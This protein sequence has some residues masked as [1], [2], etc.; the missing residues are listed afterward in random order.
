MLDGAF[1]QLDDAITALAAVDV[2][3]LTPGELDA[4]VT[5]WMQARHRLAGA[6]ESVLARWDSIGVW[7]SDGSRSAAGRFSRD[8]ATSMTTA[9]IEL[10]RARTL[11]AMPAAAAAVAAGQI[12]MDHVDLLGRADQP[13]RHDLFIRDEHVLVEQC[14]T[15][16]HADAV[17]AVEYWCQ[18]ADTDTGESTNTPPPATSTLHAS[19]TLDGT[20]RIDG[21]LQAIDGTIVSAELTR[22][23]RQLYLADEK[24]GV[25]RTHSERMAAAL[26]EMATRS[27][28]TPAGA[29]RPKP[30]FTA[31]LGDD[32]VT[33]LCELANGVVI[34]PDVLVPYL[35]TA[36]IETIL[37]DGPFTVI[38]ASHT[39][40]FTGRLRRAIQVRD[41]RCQHPSGCDVHVEG[42]DID[43][44]V[45]HTNGGKTTQ[46][47]GRLEC[48]P[49]NRDATK[50]DHDAV[51]LPER[52]VTIL[53]ELRARLRWR[54]LHGDDSDA[55][56]GVDPDEPAA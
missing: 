6:G 48:R 39:R 49:H 7:R 53:D 10:R 52:P 3:T 28:S 24:A 35:G 30:L 17:R 11:S 41:R 9:R 20:V 34:T 33:R 40:T 19:T 23:E 21:T 47:N 16:S 37:F 18:S 38:A 50:H 55:D 12:S 8:C 29:Q 22:L 51:P 2:D 1:D 31:L 46:F 54:D 36:E 27:A 43:H 42:C 45:A 32:T 13:H 15:L 56:D 25:S 44:I 4:F 5:G 26:V 14:V